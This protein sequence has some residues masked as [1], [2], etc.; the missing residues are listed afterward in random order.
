VLLAKR[1]V[2]RLAVEVARN[3]PQSTATLRALL[4]LEAAK[5]SAAL[6]DYSSN[7]VP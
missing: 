7:K 6:S 5:A 1:E 2:A 4:E 3:A